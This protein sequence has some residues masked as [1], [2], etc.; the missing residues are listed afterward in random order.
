MGYVSTLPCNQ[1]IPNIVTLLTIN[2]QNRPFFV[3]QG[4][5]INRAVTPFHEIQHTRIQMTSLMACF[6][7]NDHPAILSCH[8]SVKSVHVLIFQVT[9][10]NSINKKTWHITIFTLWGRLSCY[11]FPHTLVLCPRKWDR[12]VPQ[13][14]F[15]CPPVSWMWM[16][17]HLL[18]QFLPLGWLYMGP[19]VRVIIHIF[20]IPVIHS[21]H[22][23]HLVYYSWRAKYIDFLVTITSFLGHCL[24]RLSFWIGGAC[25]DYLN[26]L[27]HR[28]LH[29]S[30]FT[31]LFWIHWSSLPSCPSSSISMFFSQEAFSLAL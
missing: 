25:H 30:I 10:W 4:Y 14:Q 7:L 28:H 15:F 22:M 12:T 19:L 9:K 20:P 26:T 16:F 5:N 1:G 3:T 11:F 31:T 27:L 24:V 2:V 8:I 17:Y 13:L 6:I 29:T 23:L 18:Y 21:T